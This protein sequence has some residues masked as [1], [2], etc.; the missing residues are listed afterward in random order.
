M[1]LSSYQQV[2]KGSIYKIGIT[3]VLLL[4]FIVHFTVHMKAYNNLKLFYIQSS[5]FNW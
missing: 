5:S 2:R 4:H 1:A 3:N